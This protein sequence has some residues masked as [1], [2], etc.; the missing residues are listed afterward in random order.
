MSLAPLLAAPWLIQLHA[1]SAIAALLL[2]TVQLLGPRR[3]A[4]HRILGRSWAGLMIVVA[5]SAAF[6]TGRDER[7]STIHLLIP[8][9]LFMLWRAIAAVRR[10]EIRRH[11]LIM[12][13]VFALALVSA[14]GFTLLPGRLMHEVVFGG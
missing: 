7:Y 9:V 10:G 3:P 11:R 1:F 12:I 14:G 2:G 6:I 13:S 5:L 4:L 8:V